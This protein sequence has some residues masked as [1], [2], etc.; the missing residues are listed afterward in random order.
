MTKCELTNN[1]YSKYQNE[2]PDLMPCGEYYGNCCGIKGRCTHYVIGRQIVATKIV[3]E[4]L[5]GELE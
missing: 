4:L 1:L 2:D 3:N 5:K